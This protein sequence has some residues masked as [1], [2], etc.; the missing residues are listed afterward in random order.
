MIVLVTESQKNVL[1]QNLIGEKVMVYYNLHKHTFSVQKSGIVFLHADFVKLKN[2]EFRVRKGGR[3]KV[4]VEKRKNVHAFVIG[5][6]VDFCEHPCEELPKN[7]DGKIVTY[8]PYKHE[9]FVIKDTEIPVFG[10]D[11][12]YMI[13]SKDKIFIVDKPE[14]KGL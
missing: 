2:V 1:S 10:A 8:N 13:N 6:L 14:L 3:E 4:N 7:P 12:V 5:T 11:E 9:S